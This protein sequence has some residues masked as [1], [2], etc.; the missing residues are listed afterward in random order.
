MSQ[1]YINQDFSN[2]RLENPKGYFRNCN[3]NNS[4]LIGEINV[5]LKDCTANPL[6]LVNPIIEHLYTPGTPL[7]NVVIQKPSLQPIHWAKSTFQL[8][9]NH[10]FVAGR[11]RKYAMD[12]LTGDR[13]KAVLDAATYVVA[14]PE[15]S[16]NDFLF[17]LPKTVWDRT[18]EFLQDNPDLPADAIREVVRKRWPTG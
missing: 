13:R 17:A 6:T 2:Q 4:F 8:S 9:H 10:E 1:K 5:V 16:W 12:K 14:H 18:E 11:M 3:L 15:L 7:P